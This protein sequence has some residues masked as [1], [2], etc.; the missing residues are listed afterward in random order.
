MS[1]EHAL[2]LA[3]AMI[4]SIEK[5]PDYGKAVNDAMGLLIEIQ[6]REKVLR[7]LKDVD[8]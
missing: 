4:Y 2:L 8:V 7:A 3:A 5:D 6:K 1:N